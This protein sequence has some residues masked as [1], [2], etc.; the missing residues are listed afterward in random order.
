M[1]GTKLQP[2]ET[3]LCVGHG[4]KPVNDHQWGPGVR[5]L[6]AIHYIISGKGYYW[7]DQKCYEVQE[8]ES[9]LIFPDTQVYYY[10][11]EK[12]PWEYIW[13]EF[14]GEEAKELVALTEFSVKSPVTN[15]IPAELAM[16]WRAYYDIPEAYAV[17]RYAIERG[18]GKLRLLLSYY[19][20]HFPKN[21]LP[22]SVDYVQAAKKFIKINYWKSELSI[23]DIVQ[24]VNIDRTYLFRLF[25]EDTGVS[26]HQY[27]TAYRIRR[28]CELL[29]S[30]ELTMKTVAF[31]VGYPDQLYF[32]KIFKKMIGKTPTQY[33]K[34]EK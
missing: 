28:A 24:H 6:F 25:K 9:F 18:S 10:P 16:E 1:K 22:V 15:A 19:I 30:S 33:Q 14:R 2:V 12:N 34:D 13:V 29:R 17:E 7:V 26:V 20:E 11:D 21:R 23:T 4:Y 5:D 31:S 8:G 32:S 3:L 27:L